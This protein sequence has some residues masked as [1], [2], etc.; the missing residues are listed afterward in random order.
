MEER[1]IQL[2]L[3]KNL[4]EVLEHFLNDRKHFDWTTEVVIKIIKSFYLRSVHQNSK[5]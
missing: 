4:R 5:L 1:I 3:P 2:V